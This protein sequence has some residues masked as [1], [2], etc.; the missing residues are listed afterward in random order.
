MIRVLA[1]KIRS[2]DPPVDI[3]EVMQQVEYLLDRSIAAEGY[4]I[5]EGEGSHGADHLIDLS[6]ID[7]E[8]LRA[9][10]ER[11]R[12]H[13]EVERV[14][15]AISRQMQKM[16]RRNRTRVDYLERFQR[17]IE[18]YNAGTINVE[19]FFRRLM[20]FAKSLNEEEQ[21]AVGENLSEEELALF[22]LL[23]K[24]EMDLTKKERERVKA[25]ART[26]LGTLKGEKL[27]LDWRKKQQSRAA[28]RLAIEETLENLPDRY[29]QEL[30]DQKCS[31]IYQ[32]V[33]ESYY[34]EDRSVYSVAA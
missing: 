27:V 2:L 8:A 18:A 24:P 19:E 17:M 12:K 26:L 30:Y 3:S 21:R 7:F 16:I 20:E 28:V 1:Q 34:G 6:G 15:G 4:V 23:T 22:D 11:G 13:T 29:S 33:F 9:R 32:H 31:A 25:T 10:F 14:K 5:R